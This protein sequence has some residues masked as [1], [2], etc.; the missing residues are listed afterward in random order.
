MN[1]EAEAAAVNVICIIAGL[2]CW[3]GLIA[4]PLQMAGVI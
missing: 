4:A 1:A 2:V 3:A